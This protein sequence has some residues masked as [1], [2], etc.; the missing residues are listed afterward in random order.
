[1][2]IEYDPDINTA[3]RPDIA[4]MI[5]ENVTEQCGCG[6]DEIYVSLQSESMI[7]IKCYDCGKSYF[8]LEME[9]EEETMEN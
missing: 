4:A 9:I 8:E 3:I 7:D 1:V 2:K 6:C 5:K